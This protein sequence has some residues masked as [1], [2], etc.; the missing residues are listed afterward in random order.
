LGLFPKQPDAICIN[1]TKLNESK[2]DLIIIIGYN[3]PFNNAATNAERTGLYSKAKFSFRERTDGKLNNAF[4][5][6]IWIENSCT[7]LQV[8][9]LTLHFL[10]NK[11]LLDFSEALQSTLEKLNF[12]RLAIYSYYRRNLISAEELYPSC[13]SFRIFSSM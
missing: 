5:E 9:V 3:F 12:Q 4:V 7:K 11:N 13:R 6:Y 10:P 8:V 2:Q 1:E